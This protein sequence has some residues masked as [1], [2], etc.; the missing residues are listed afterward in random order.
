M[1]ESEFKQLTDHLLEKNK[2]VNFEVEL[3]IM[4]ALFLIDCTGSMGTTL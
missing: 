2:G 4:K 1:S 3:K